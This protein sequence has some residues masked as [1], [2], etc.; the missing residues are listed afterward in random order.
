MTG[1][2]EFFDR[3]GTVIKNPRIGFVD[4]V[5]CYLSLFLPWLKQDGRPILSLPL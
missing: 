2:V 4:Q 3:D 5:C 1:K